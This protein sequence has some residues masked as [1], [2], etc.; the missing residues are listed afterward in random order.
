MLNYKKKFSI[1]FHGIRGS[2]PIPDKKMFKFGGNTACVEINVNNH[3][4][5]VDAG[6]GIIELGNQLLKDYIA[7]GTSEYDRKP[8]NLMVLFSHFHYDHIQGFHFFKPAYVGTSNIYMFGSKHLGQDFESIIRE[9]M[10][11]PVFPVDLGEMNANLYFNN[12]MEKDI[13][14]LRPNSKK[15]EV[16]KV[17]VLYNEELDEDT[18]VISCLKSSAH[19][20]DGVLIF[21]VSWQ[22]KSFVYASD[23]E[24]YVGGDYRLANFAR[25][26]DILVH[27]SQYIQED[28][29]MPISPRQGFGH[30]TPE[31]A[32]ETAKLGNVEKLIL[33][34]IDPSYDDKV[35]NKIEENAK[36]LFPNVQ[37]AYEGLEIDLI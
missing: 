26:A 15:P 7:S 10:L 14:L 21:K 8:I 25:K 1:K 31:I 36:K 12:F 19:P 37:V 23:K 2:H 32:I 29:L 4:I 13:I 24:G 35:V 28:Y 5:I 9:S 34:H 20:K 3:L 11:S 18:V 22:G 33:Y 17:S 30:S 6:T 27:D 16:N